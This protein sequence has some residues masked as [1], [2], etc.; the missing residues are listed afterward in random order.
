MDDSDHAARGFIQAL[1]TQ[2]LFS[3][4]PTLVDENTKLKDIRESN[5]ATPRANALFNWD[6]ADLKEK[7]SINS[8]LSKNGTIFY[9]N[10]DQNSFGIGTSIFESPKDMKSDA[11]EI[12][13]FRLPM[14]DIEGSLRGLHESSPGHRSKLRSINYYWEKIFGSISTQTGE[15][16]STRWKSI[17]FDDDGECEATLISRS[18][19][20]FKPIYL[21]S[22]EN[23]AFFVLA[24]IISCRLHNCVVLLDEPELHMSHETQLRY[25][26]V[27]RE[28]GE[29]F[30]IQFIIATHSVWLA[31]KVFSE[32]KDLQL[33]SSPRP[34]PGN[35]R[36][37]RSQLRLLERNLGGV[38][39]IDE[40]EMIV[41]KYRDLSRKFFDQYI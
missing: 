3:R 39:V 31:D 4:P 35:V 29:K 14:T 5:R 25:Y 38:N 7:S 15:F 41:K 10:T 30:R 20:E 26:R 1:K 9:I 12:C 22:G 11:G 13:H 37:Q 2:I 34:H 18:G 27:L 19:E 24:T 32:D 8:N 28:L 40:R 21:S 23:E 33:T 17:H 36:S 16:I 6:K